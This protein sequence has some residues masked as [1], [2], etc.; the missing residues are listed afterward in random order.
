MRERCDVDAF[1]ALL[2]ES[3]TL[4]MPAR[5]TWYTSREKHDGPLIVFQLFRSEYP[6]RC[7]F[8]GISTSERDR[9]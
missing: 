5:A 1:T 4:A 6:E 2:V 8:V 3:A 9:A 7:P